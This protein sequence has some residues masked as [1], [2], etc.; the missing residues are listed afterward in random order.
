MCDEWGCEH[1]RDF[2][3]LMVVTMKEL[4]N[5]RVASEVGVGRRE[6]YLKYH[7]S[8][9]T[10]L[11]IRKYLSTFT[12]GIKPYRLSYKSHSFVTMVNSC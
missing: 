7:K 8:S 1:E 3:R 11:M 5:A 4:V 10:R 9:E 2:R 6:K 12:V